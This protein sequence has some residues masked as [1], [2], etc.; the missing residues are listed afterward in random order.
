MIDLEIKKSGI[1]HNGVF[2]LKKFAK[3]ERICFMTGKTMTLDE[4]IEAV[5][6]GYERGSDP[7]QI[8]LKKYLDLDELPRSFNHSCEPNAFLRGKNELVA[9]KKIKVG[10]EIFF[11]YSTTMNDNKERIEETGGALWTCRC[12][13][14]AKKCRGIIDQFKTLPKTVQNFYLKNKFAPDFILKKFG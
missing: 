7:L 1:S 4:M 6:N 10:E 12:H 5:D 3:G 9:L 14:G 2:A 11:D 8:G 13:C